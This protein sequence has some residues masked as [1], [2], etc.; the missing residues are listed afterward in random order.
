M[1]SYR[2]IR[3]LGEVFLSREV[4]PPKYVL[5]AKLTCILK[6]SFYIGENLVAAEAVTER[7]SLIPYYPYAHK[8]TATC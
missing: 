4:D 7:Y 5:K 3:G 8:N 2:G 6:N 1:V